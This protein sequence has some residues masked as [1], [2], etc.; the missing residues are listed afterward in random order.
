MSNTK[1][2]QGAVGRYATLIV[3][4]LLG[5]S[6][7]AFGANAFWPFIPQP[8]PGTFPPE[9]MQ[10]TMALAESGYMTEFIGATHLLVGL[11]LLANRFVPL[12]LVIFAAF[13]A[14]SLAFHLFL[15]PTGLPMSL[16]FTAA[17]LY[18]A[19][20]HRAAYRALLTPKL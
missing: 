15:E 3:R 1:K 18:L 8:E 20:V 13:M 19:W 17:L 14:N 4:L 12:A 16:V 11:A 9:V 7:L 5:L 2:P 10:F 6:L